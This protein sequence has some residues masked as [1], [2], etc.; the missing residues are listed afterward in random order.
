MD[1]PPNVYLPPPPPPRK[2]GSGLGHGL[3]EERAGAEAAERG[4]GGRQA[5]GAVGRA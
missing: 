5:S 3:K 1:P 2:R 4:R